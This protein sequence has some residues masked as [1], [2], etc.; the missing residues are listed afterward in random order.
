MKVVQFGNNE[1][2]DAID[3]LESTI[4]RVKAGEITAV[5][6]S[7]V[8]GNSSISGD[9]S[10]GKNNLLMWAA[11]EHAAKSFYNEHISAASEEIT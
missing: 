1:N 11:L 7:W 8:E 4:A 6:V 9:V 5:A 3:L 10:N 2:K